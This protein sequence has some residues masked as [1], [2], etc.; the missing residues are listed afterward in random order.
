M[1]HA[2]EHDTTLLTTHFVHLQLTL[3]T[4]H[5]TLEDETVDGVALFSTLF[6]GVEGF[7]PTTG[8]GVNL[9][10]SLVRIIDSICGKFDGFV[11]LSV[12]SEPLNFEL[13]SVNGVEAL[14]HTLFIRLIA[15]HE[16]GRI[17][18]RKVAQRATRL[19]VEDAIWRTLTCQLEGFVDELHGLLR[20]FVHGDVDEIHVDRWHTLFI[21]FLLHAMDDIPE[22]LLG[23]LF[24]TAVVIDMPHHVDSHI[25]LLVEFLLGEFARELLAQ[26]VGLEDVHVVQLEDNLV[27]TLS[28]V[29]MLVTLSQ[30]IVLQG[31]YGGVKART[32]AIVEGMMHR[33]AEGEI[34]LRRLIVISSP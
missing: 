19:D 7:L 18:Q 33:V 17:A 15:L 31:M 23:S 29:G 5:R 4:L 12:G 14:G 8:L 3:D 34:L 16:I 26:S 6:Q 25:H 28:I 2:I 24:V 10:L 21:A 9:G 20:V 22:T 11:S 32:V 13:S 1:N 30:Q 27:A